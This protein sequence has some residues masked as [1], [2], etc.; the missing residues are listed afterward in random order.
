MEI[1]QTLEEKENNLKT[2]E[3]STEQNANMIDGIPNNESPRNNQGYVI[4]ES[5]VV[6]HMEYV[7]AE[8][9]KAPQPYVTWARNVTN[10]EQSGRENFFWGH[11]FCGKEAAKEDF[12]KRVGEEQE[13]VSFKKE[14]P[15]L[16]ESLKRHQGEVAHNGRESISERGRGGTER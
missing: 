6:G 13:R 16:I 14:R 9:S 7:F 4:L 1:K 5:E 8:N 11:Y 2:V 12:Y 15:S 3:P 10:D